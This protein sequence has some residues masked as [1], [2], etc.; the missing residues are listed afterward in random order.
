MKIFKEFSPEG[1]PCPVCQTHLDGKTILVPKPEP[2]SVGIRECVQMH[3]ECAE[4]VLTDWLRRA[5]AP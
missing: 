2:A 5:C 1:P 4:A 3:A